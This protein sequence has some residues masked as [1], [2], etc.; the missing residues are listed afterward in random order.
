ML[1]PTSAAKNYSHKDLI[2]KR[3]TDFALPTGIPLITGHTHKPRLNP[4]DLSYMN[5]GSCVHPRCITC[6]ELTGSQ[7]TLVKWTCDT[8]KDRTLFVSREVLSHATLWEKA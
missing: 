5:T 8:R 6:M 1:D 3:L 4:S 2:E 7:L